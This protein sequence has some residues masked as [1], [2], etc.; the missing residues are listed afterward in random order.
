MSCTF[1]KSQHNVNVT[2]NF[3]LSNEINAGY[4]IY[5]HYYNVTAKANVNLLHHWRKRRAHG[6]RYLDINYYIYFISLKILMFNY[7]NVEDIKSVFPYEVLHINDLTAHLFIM[8]DGA[9]NFHNILIWSIVFHLSTMNNSILLKNQYF[10][11]F[12]CD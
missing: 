12:I 6:N 10:V 9:E 7:F 11:L 1:F 2:A 4:I 5:K 8:L 3:T